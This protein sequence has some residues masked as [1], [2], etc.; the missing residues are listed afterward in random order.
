[1]HN[2]VLHYFRRLPEVYVYYYA[3]LDGYHHARFHRDFLKKGHKARQKNLRDYYG[4][5]QS[6]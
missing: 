4:F 6:L 5:F 1:M 2:I 3:E